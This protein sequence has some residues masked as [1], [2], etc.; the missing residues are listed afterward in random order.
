MYSKEIKELLRMRNNLV[1][2]KEYLEICNSSQID[3]IKYEDNKFKIW[4]SDN[5]YFELKILQK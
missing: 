2:V 4:S 1:S 5:Y 3:H